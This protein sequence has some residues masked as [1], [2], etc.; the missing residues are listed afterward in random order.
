MRI[1]P[2]Y[3]GKLVR[4]YKR[5]LADIILEDG[6]RI[7]AHCP[8]SGSMKTL[9]DEG[10]ACYVTHD[11][12][13]HRKLDYTLQFIDAEGIACVNT[14]IPNEIVNEALID[15]KLPFEFKS[16]NREEVFHDSRLDFFL[17]PWFIEVKNVTMLYGS[18]ASFPDAVTTRGKKH[19][20]SLQ[21]AVREG[22]QAGI[23]YVVNHMGASSFSIADWIDSAY[24]EELKKAVAGGVQVFVYKSKI[25]LGEHAK[26]TISSPLP[27]P[28]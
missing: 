24:Y 20:V 28:F 12:S 13:P 2:L 19:L 10:N 22:Y 11:P 1:G 7:T 25:I 16:I 27:F 4:R 18:V 8:N 21:Q 6:T 14:M 9:D 3:K 26:I 23:F 17:D 5:F 15:G